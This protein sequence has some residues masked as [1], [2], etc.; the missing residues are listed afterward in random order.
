M[1]LHVKQ[2][3]FPAARACIIDICDNNC[4][5]APSFKEHLTVPKRSKVRSRSVILTRLS[6]L[7]V[8][9]ISEN[10]SV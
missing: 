6:R 3:A 4:E 8:S 10:I 1:S 2:R 9:H 5:T 7:P